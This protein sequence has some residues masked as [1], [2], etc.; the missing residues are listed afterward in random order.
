M[1]R[2]RSL[3]RLNG[4]LRASSAL[5]LL[6]LVAFLVVN[7]SAHPTKAYEPNLSAQP[8]AVIPVC[9]PIA[10]NTTWTAVNLY[11]ITDCPVTITA[12]V[13]LTVEP[14]TTVKFSGGQAALIINGALAAQ[15]TAA[16]PITFSSLHDNAHGQIAPG[17][18]GSPAAQDWYGLHFAPGSSGQISH[19][20]IGYGTADASV[21]NIG[22]NRAQIYADAAAIQ[23]ANL[24]IGHGF[25]AGVY[26]QGGG[27]VQIT[28]SFVHHHN[29]ATAYP[30]ASAIYQA[31]LNMQPTYSNLTFSD[32]GRNEVTLDVNTAMTQD[33][34]L[35]GA[36]FGFLCGS[37]LCVL[38]VPNGRTL[39]INPGTLLD[40]RAPYGIIVAAGGS[41]IA[42]GTPAQP[43]T[44]TSQ[45]AAAGDP[46]QVWTGLWAQ[47]E[48]QIALTHCDISYATDTNYGRG[49]L[50][51]NTHTA[52][53]QN[54]HIHHNA[55]NGLYLYS[56]TGHDLTVT[57]AD[58]D[59]TDNGEYGIF[60]HASSGST[61]AVNWQGGSSANNGWAGVMGFTPASA[62]DPTFSNVTIANNGALGGMAGQRRG[63]NFEYANIN[64]TL[65]NVALN[66]NVGTAVT[67]NC[68][69]SISAHNLTASGNG[70][71][72]LELP[73]CV[74]SGGRQWDLGDGGLPVR[75]RGH[76]ELTASS[77]LS[78]QPGTAL[79]FGQ[80]IALFVADYAALYALGTADQP[81]VFTGDTA[82]TGW[83]AGME[84]RDR[85]TVSLRHCEIAYGGRNNAN[86]ILANLSLLPGL[87]GV[88]PTAVIQNCDI[89]HS[90]RKG[91]HFNYAGVAPSPAPLVR[92][93]TIHDNAQEG[94]VNWNAPPLDA[95]DNYWGDPT[96]PYH[97]TQ[98]PG[99]L[100][101]T[102]GD[103]IIFYPWLV[104][105]ASGDE[106][107]GGVLVNTG[108]PTL[109]SPGETVDY[110]LQYLNLMTETVQNGV[111]LLQLPR[112]ANYVSSTGGGIYWPENHQLF[113]PLG[114]IP[115]GG[116]EFLSVRLRFD[117]GL[118][119]DFTDGTI[120]LLSGD[121]YNPDA[122]DRDTYLAYEPVTATAVAPLT[123]ANF[124]ALR[125]LYPDLQT[126]YQASLTEGY[127][128]LE[129][130]TVTYSNGQAVQG[131]VLRTANRQNV[132]LLTVQDGQAMA[133][134]VAGG[135]FSL[136][137][138]TGGMSEDLQTHQRTFWGNWQPEMVNGRLPTACDETRCKFHCI[139]KTLSVKVVGGAVAKFFFWSL[140]TGG[141]G[142]LLS[143]GYQVYSI[144]RS[145][146]DCRNECNVN[147]YIGC[148]DA[149]GQVRWS[150]GLLP[151]YC[152]KA[153]CNATTGTW[154]TPGQL[155][156]DGVCMAGTAEQGGGC[157]S[158]AGET[159]MSQS[160]LSLC[161]AGSG[162]CT[163]TGLLVARD[164]NAIYGPAGDLLPGQTVTYTITYE[165]E[166]AG[167][168]YGV[169]VV[170][171]LPEVMDESSLTF[172]HHS[173]TYLPDS[174]EILWWVGELGPQGAP[175]AEGVIT[176]TVALTAGLPSGTAVANQ[177][178]VYFSSVPEETPTNTWVNLVA[179]LSATPQQLSTDY[180]TPLP[181]V[182]DG[183]DVSALPLTYEVVELPR[184]GW[185]NGAPPNITYTPYENFTGDDGFAFQVSNGT[186]TSRPA[187]VSIRVMPDGDT[188]P[189]QVW[190]TNPAADAMAVAVSATAIFTDALS[191]LYAPAIAAGLSEALD[192]ATVTSDTVTL[193]GEGGTA[194]PARVRFAGNVNQIV[195]FP[196]VVLTPGLYTVMVTTAV[197]DLAGNPLT[198]AVVW[199]FT[200]AGAAAG[201]V[202][203]L[204]LVVK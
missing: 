42:E 30:Y 198:G 32:N 180:M 28:D 194:V 170:N 78:L 120:A 16:Q 105:P 5:V 101:E 15:G 58:V 23:F 18:S 35:G 202:V 11:T 145:V 121:N 197:R 149:E 181:V 43:I 110:A 4:A 125:V 95:R 106:L 54:C 90:G 29:G 137:D 144:T 60:L 187:H 86:N 129:A 67:W 132:R 162:D 123:Q 49:G 93:N 159:Q 85:A 160:A 200:T 156:C 161:A 124:D 12:G 8:Q 199:S 20:F 171:P 72:E 57:L 14:G 196:R 153:Y 108:A 168:A 6:F 113:W 131:A 117:W 25:R 176:Y 69:G 175:D 115:S 177:A 204:P 190:W 2:Y 13:T 46:T 189:P 39:T 183:R 48:S 40:F 195:L 188:T 50:E 164:P 167:R 163:H 37:S 114:D 83:W 152:S 192:M 157:K 31:S 158:C 87:S 135:L 112:A 126:L 155:P 96:G 22:A 99:G 118:P 81:V 142:G 172:I 73:G 74:L 98:N 185:L 134:T 169:Y 143:G 36:D 186:S 173:G 55:R 65:E 63:L 82:E 19:A 104:A 3:T 139:G 44:F 111:L 193:Q 33:V 52:Q 53:V 174:R 68:N 91:L 1:N 59:V 107:P 84:A 147:P 122:F 94:L 64:P 103:N 27:S 138:T 102:V 92:Y 77:L 146:L 88:A 62:I 140:A 75:V 191:P 7:L 100:G 17:S 182:L 116:Q 119:L 109:V 201:H 203:Y 130:G 178:T 24:E 34:T 80:N 47:Q 136:H 79:R 150:P 133:I 97:P 26:L 56:P 71:D 21:P 38:T 70:A 61:L 165:N 89:H 45:L 127:A 148:C 10:S 9:G 141:T 51:I 184:G 151:G 76:I 41:L 154:G 128:Y 166:G 66:G 179:P